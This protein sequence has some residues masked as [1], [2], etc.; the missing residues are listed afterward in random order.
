MNVKPM[1]LLGFAAVIGMLGVS[2]ALIVSV[3]QGGPPDA[4]SEGT[5]AVFS[6]IVGA[7]AG[8]S[9]QDKAKA[10]SQPSLVA[11]DE[12]RYVVEDLPEGEDMPLVDDDEL[13]V[14]EDD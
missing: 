7:I 5:F 2:V 14:H 12:A 11:D 1:I 9:V 4:L 6:A 3:A 13:P 10:E 8:Y